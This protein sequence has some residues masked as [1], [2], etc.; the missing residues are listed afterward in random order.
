MV[1]NSPPWHDVSF[2]EMGA[3]KRRLTL[4]VA[5]ATAV[6]AAACGGR[7]PR[8]ADVAGPH[9]P[10]DV[11]TESAVPPAAPSLE[12]GGGPRFQGMIERIDPATGAELRS[13]TWHPGCPVPISHLRL[14]T[15][16]YWGFD[17]A[18][19]EGPMIVNE[20][21]AEDVVRVFGRLFRA[22]FPIKRI[23]LARRY[24]P[25]HDRPTK[26]DVTAAFNCRPATDNP[27]VWSQHAYGLAID[28]NPLQN[29]YV[30]SDGSVLRPAARPY[31]DRSLDESG[32]I[33]AGDVVVRAF[34]RIGWGWG[35]D[36]TSIRDYQHFSSTGR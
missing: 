30:R 34:A 8:A 6:L 25:N 20:N 17:G 5:V 3:F 7:A 29:P 33:H 2:I 14:L 12:A 9:P 28:I 16:S 24:R 18:V 4:V 23:A 21:V 35:G 26:N 11:V 31:T 15:L 19:H 32:M 1:W 27:G 36:Y 10:S 13:T 22:R